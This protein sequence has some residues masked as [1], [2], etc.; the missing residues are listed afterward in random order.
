MPARRAS[1]AT[2]LLL[3]A[4]CSPAP[5]PAPA[6]VP[7]TPRRA[8]TPRHAPSPPVAAARPAPAPAPPTPV[9]TGPLGGATPVI[10][11]AAAGDASWIATC[12]ATTDTN[13]DGKIGVDVGKA[14]ALSGDTLSPSL[15]IGD[16]AP[17]P[18]D[19]I[20]A[21][22]GTGRY[23]V[24][25]KSG[26]LVL[27]DA[28]A[29][30]ETTLDGADVRD[31]AT[32][33]APHRAVSFDA[34]GSR[35]MFVRRGT[36]RSDVVVRDLA[37]GKEAHVDPGPGKLWRAELSPDGQLVVLRMIVDDTNKNGKL[38]WPVPERKKNDWR[39]HGPIPTYSAW[40]DR[41]DTPVVEI[42][43]S[44]GGKARRVD[45]F[46]APFAGA[47]LV[48]DKNDRLL[49]DRGASPPV[50]LADGKCAA[51][52]LHADPARGLLVAACS[53][54]K[55]RPPVEILGQGVRQATGFD[56]GAAPSDAWPDAEPQ[57][58]FAFQPGADTA[59][60]DLDEQSVH[61]LRRGD[62]VAATWG[63]LAL[64]QRGRSLLIY[65]ADKKTETALAGSVQ[66]DADPRRNGPVAVV[67]PLVVDLAAP[68]LLGRV[69]HAP[70]AVAR[71]GRVLVAEGGDA[72]ASQLAVGPLR[73]V[74]PEP[75]PAPSPASGAPN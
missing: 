12:A 25:K 14:G 65:D 7:P 27:V 46:V 8:P 55:L 39:C 36:P 69:D 73:W 71:D 22:D 72:T 43:P 66:A 19:E 26:K 17:E 21:F 31:D 38:G 18:V 68:R 44:S 3:F 53:G 30:T 49:L 61:L 11:E 15:L 35:L 9:A 34:T 41:G 6:S 47:A 70:L 74:T 2:T 62:R 45:G 5:L 60:V 59:L 75:L 29:R 56:L 33:Y 54:E 20:A 64:V 23:L 10:V 32:P 16:A 48:R 13:G 57:R 37:T 1:I 67:A 40:L 50:E 51:H 42:A 58:L 63:A 52:V 28:H 24:V 4:A